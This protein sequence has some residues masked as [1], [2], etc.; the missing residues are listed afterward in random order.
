EEKVK[1]RPITDTFYAPF[2]LYK[3]NKFDQVLKGLIS[4]HAQNEDTAISDSMTKKMFEDEK[5]GMYLEEKVKERPITDTFYAPFDLYKPNK[6][7]QVLKGLISSHAQNEDTAISDSMTKK[8]FEDEKTGGEG[9]KSVPS[10]TPSML[11]ST[12]T[13]PTSFDQVLKGLISSHAQN[14]GHRHL[15][16]H[17]QKDV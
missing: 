11:P 5:T 10:Q 7:D 12:F 17:D 9:E 13:S 6:F 14:E 4:S 8:M 2:D 15:R 1:E 16:L 3:P